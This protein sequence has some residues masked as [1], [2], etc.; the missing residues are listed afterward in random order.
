MSDIKFQIDNIFKDEVVT[1]YVKFGT[2]FAINISG[3]TSKLG[4]LTYATQITGAAA[5]GGNAPVAFVNE[6]MREKNA[7]Q[8]TYVN[9]NKQYPSNE[10]E[11]V[12]KTSTYQI[13]H[14]REWYK[15]VKKYFKNTHPTED[16][17]IAYISKLYQK[18]RAPI[19]QTK[20]MTLHFF[21]DT[22]RFNDKN[23]EFWLRML[24]L[25]M[26]VGKRFA[27]HAKIY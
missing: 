24:Y 11:F 4:N 13:K 14:Y 2:K 20:L 26:K 9:K 17:F 1:T 7:N 25:G 27:A 23:K 22:L 10:M 15:F 18:N 8:I 19:A 12:S 5:Q 21:Y 3:S 6:L 16:K